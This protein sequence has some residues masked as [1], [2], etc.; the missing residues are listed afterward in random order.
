MRVVAFNGSARKNGNTTR[1]IK[2][3]FAELEKEGIETELVELAGKKLCGCQAC[4]KCS[5]SKDRKCAQ[6]DEV[7]EYVKKMAASDGII[8]ASP[9]YFSD[10][11][12]NMKA[13]IE[14]AGMV[15]RANGNLYK[16]KLGAAIVA[17]RRAGAAHAFASMNQFFLIEQMI[18]VGSSYW[19]IGIGREIGEV[20][21]DD[22]GMRTMRD[23]GS[24]L[25]WAI[26]KLHG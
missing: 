19:N 9:T 18:V 16:R 2:A 22:E 1:L 8:L 5:K 17:V 15:G 14:R 3:V 6:D 20:E 7:N 13:L 11:S 26:K 23:L 25:A 21:N 12:A 24:N 10:I 4:Y